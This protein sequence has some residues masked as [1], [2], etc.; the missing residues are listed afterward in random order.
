MSKE[1]AAAAAGENEVIKMPDRKYFFINICFVRIP[2]P[3]KSFLLCGRAFY[4]PAVQ[5]T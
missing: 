2:S 3:L 4:D 5:H 1:A